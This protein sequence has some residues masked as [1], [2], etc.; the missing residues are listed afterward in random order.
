MALAPVNA[1]YSG[2]QGI[3]SSKHTLAN[4]RH[5]YSPGTRKN[6]TRGY[7]MRC[8]DGDEDRYCNI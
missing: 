3:N 2:T 1:V 7:E 5:S 6:E 4:K 8:F